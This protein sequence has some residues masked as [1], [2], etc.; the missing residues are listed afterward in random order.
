MFRSLAILLIVATTSQAG[1][2][3]YIAKPEPAFSWSL[4]KKHELPTGEVHVLKMISQ[5][6]QG[7]KWEHGLVVYTPKQ[8]KPSETMFMYNTGGNPNITND[9]LGLQLAERMQ[10]PVA[11]L[12]NIPNQ[13]LYGGKKEDALIAETYV[14]YLETKDE[15]W[16]LL[17]PMVKSVI[18]AMDVIQVY[19]KQA[20]SM[21]VKKFVISGASKRGWTSWLS[22]ASEDPRII[23]IAPMVID[24]LNMQKQMKYQVESYGK[25][26]DQVKD[27]TERGLIPMPK[28]PE[29]QRLWEMVD[30][31]NYR[32]KYQMPKLIINGTNDP[33]W[34]QDATNLYWDE[35][36]GD[37]YLLYVPN[38]GHGLEQTYATGKKDR[39]R[40]VNTLATFGKYQMQGK[41][42]PKLTWKHNDKDEKPTLRV[43]SSETPKKIRLW[44]ADSATRDFRQSKW[45]ESFI[46]TAGNVIE[47]SIELPKSGFRVFFTEL[48]FESSG[49]PF[50]LSTQLRIVGK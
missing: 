10:A 43:E 32:A 38:A 47:S 50:F 8:Y 2:K 33:Y 25:P 24:T 20:F 28:T 3:E 46:Q 22:G 39:D 7:M 41:A 16:P 45:T 17:F 19:S 44:T 9:I 11:F 40:A 49:I 5:E 31:F 26:S 18:K 23:A 34:T 14:R 30:P 48:E 21:E 42:F 1:L 12:F 4:V 37:K 6:W 13:P 27:Y 15:S 36:P 35:L 29:A